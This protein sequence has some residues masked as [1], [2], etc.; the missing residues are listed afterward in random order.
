MALVGPAASGKATT[1]KLLQAEAGGGGGKEKSAENL[2]TVE[3]KNQKARLLVWGADDQIAKFA[4]HSASESAPKGT[5][6]SVSRR[7]STV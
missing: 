7:A 6:S 2:T 5:L 4:K 1:L 3:L